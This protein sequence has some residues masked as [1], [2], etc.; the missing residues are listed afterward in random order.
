MRHCCETLLLNTLLS[1]I[2]YGMD[3]QYRI[4]L[5]EREEQ[6]LKD[7]QL[8]CLSDDLKAIALA[9]NYNTH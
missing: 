1:K 7:M 9:S 5:I 4:F 2:P 3:K 6:R 8:A